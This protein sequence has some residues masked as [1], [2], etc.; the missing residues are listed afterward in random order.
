MTLSALLDCSADKL[1]KMS[2]ADLLKHFAQYLDVTRPERA[3]VTKPQQ[4]KKA[5][6]MTPQKA[7]ALKVLGSIDGIDMDL[8][9]RKK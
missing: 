8:F 6:Y 9:R 5:P 3:R 4:Q 7:R 1:E 2:D